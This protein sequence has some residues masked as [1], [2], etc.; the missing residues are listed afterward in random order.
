VLR[1]DD[2]GINT[3]WLAVRIIF[4]GDLGFAV[5]PQVWAEAIFSYF[6]E[7]L[8]KF[9]S[10]RDRGGH[11]IGV[12]VNGEAEHH[13]LIAGAARVDAHSN[14]AG[15]LV[16]ARD[17]SAGVAVEAIERVVVTNR[18][19]DAADQGLEVYVSFGSD[20]SGDDDEA[21]SSE[22]LAGDAAGRIFRQAGVEDRIGNLVSNFIWVSFG[23]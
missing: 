18:L 3:D 11:E 4:D 14:V 6:G 8:G 20:F 23:D 7:T 15:L 2:D 17:H 5:G 19:N 9:V 16:D 13:T 22:S 10:K 1:G 12:L 21:S